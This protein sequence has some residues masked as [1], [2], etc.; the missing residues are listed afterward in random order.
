MRNIPVFLMLVI[1]FTLIVAVG[2]LQAV[3]AESQTSTTAPVAVSNDQTATSDTADH[4]RLDLILGAL[5]SA[6]AWAAFKLF[7]VKLSKNLLTAG[8]GLLLDIIQNIKTGPNTAQLTDYEK[9]KE[10][11]AQ[12]T[13]QLSQTHIK[14]LTKVFGSL[15]GAIE[16]V[17][18]NKS[19][20][21]GVG[22]VVGSLL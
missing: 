8:L 20:L 13:A 19:V 7:R 2:T 1:L 22:K 21:G 18:H 10:A 9:K 4:N 16:Y 17:F 12:A 11:V 15:G 6:I 3:Q 5:A 14:L